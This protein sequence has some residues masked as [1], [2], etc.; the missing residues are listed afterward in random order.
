MIPTDLLS[1]SDEKLHGGEPVDFSDTGKGPIGD[2]KLHLPS[3]PADEFG[4]DAHDGALE[5]RGSFTEACV[6]RK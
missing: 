2:C 1:S 3:I 4:D 6:P 5:R